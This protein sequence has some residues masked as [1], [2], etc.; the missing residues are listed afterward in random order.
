MSHWIPRK[1]TTNIMQAVD[2]RD[3]STH[4]FYITSAGGEGKT[5][6]L[7]QLGEALGSP[8]GIAP[9]GRWLGIIDLYHSDVNTPSGLERHL[10]ERL[11]EYTTAFMDYFRMRDEL[12]DMQ[13]SGVPAGDTERVR[14]E[15]A[16]KFIDGFNDAAAHMRPVIALDTAERM[17]YQVDEVQRRHAIERESTS[18]RAWLLEQLPHWR[19]CI[20]LVVGRPD[21]NPEEE[22]RAGFGRALAER[23]AERPADAEEIRYHRLVLGGFDPDEACEFFE[24][25]KTGMPGDVEIDERLQERLRQVFDGNPIRLEMALYLAAAGHGWDALRATILRGAAEEVREQADRRLIELTMEKDEEGG[26]RRVLRY[27]AVARKGLT[28][29]LLAHLLG[30]DDLEGCRALLHAVA[31]RPFVKTR[32]NTDAYFLHDAMYELCD[33]HLLMPDTVQRASRRIV[34]WY[35]APGQ[36]E[37]KQD[38]RKVDSLLYRLRADAGAG[39]DWFLRED[40]EAVRSAQTELDMRLHN[41]LLAFLNSPSVIDRRMIAATSPA[42]AERFEADNAAAWVKRLLFRGKNKEAKR[43]ADEIMQSRPAFVHDPALYLGWAEFAVFA[44]QTGIYLAEPQQAIALL[45]EVIQALEGQESPAAVAARDAGSFEDRRRNLLLGR[46]HNN[47]GY[48]YWLPQGHLQ[49]ALAEFRAASAYFQHSRLQEELANTDDN[50]GRVYALLR[51]RTRGEMLVEDGLEI[52]RQL[53][54]EYRMALSL[55][56]LAVVVQEFG[57]PERARVFANRARTICERLNVRRGIGL[58][59]IT[60]GAA[61]RNMGNDDAL[62]SLSEAEDLYSES[63]RYL[64]E[65]LLIFDSSEVDEP[66]RRVEAL[67]E[68]GSAHRNWAKRLLSER[69]GDAARAEGLLR[70][71]TH[72]YRDCIRLAEEKGFLA[73]YVDGCEDLAEAY[74]A[75]GRYD[76]AREWLDRAAAKTPDAYKIGPGGPSP[77]LRDEECVELLWLMLGKI[78]LARGEV[79]A[80]IR[81]DPNDLPARR[82]WL[83][84]V[85]EHYV[86]SAYYFE[87][88]ASDRTRL[89][90]TF[91]RMYKSLKGSS[92]GE[93]AYVRDTVLPQLGA[94]YKIDTESRPETKEQAGSERLGYRRLGNFFDDTL[95]ATLG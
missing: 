83:R 85:V 69:P 5:V 61:L 33:A 8:G 26:V 6:L 32:P 54:R 14:A 22:E 72:Y 37:E 66:V 89:E 40:D 87:R 92:R 45:K 55:N 15:V 28:A 44:A 58:A 77:R 82:D 36:P 11:E 65:A 20:V 63:L 48:V 1:L 31:D 73:H 59:N 17:Q 2:A 42:L 67:N 78:E 79:E 21:A 52:R 94:E 76:E 46:A 19:N 56:S 50:M 18:L 25:R 84:R 70:S 3:G 29:E 30:N 41:E 57:T 27:L 86:L 71:A 24:Q 9:A 16:R 75:G 90:R 81:P 91:S 35:D 88:F 7:R 64:R 12:V 93:L 39:Y 60:L 95:G 68:L 47:L 51:H 80:A 74:M 62:Y 43:V 23:L 10:A 34:E 4:I 49:A 13:R 53:G 38:D